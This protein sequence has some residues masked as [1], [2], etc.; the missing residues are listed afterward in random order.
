MIC[1]KNNGTEIPLGRTLIAFNNHMT[2]QS[3]LIQSNNIVWFVYYWLSFKDYGSWGG[4]GGKRGFFFLK[5]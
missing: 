2:Q 5:A 3:D 4:G 1:E